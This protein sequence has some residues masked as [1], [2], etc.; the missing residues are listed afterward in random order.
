LNDK[1]V[2]GQKL[3]LVDRFNDETTYGKNADT[4]IHTVSN[5][6]R[7]LEA[8]ACS[9][10]TAPNNWHRNRWT[11]AEGLIPKLFFPNGC[12]IC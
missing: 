1:S 9:W 6:A 3:P 11:V 8:C 10:A 2:S 5:D 4:S 12:E 7:T